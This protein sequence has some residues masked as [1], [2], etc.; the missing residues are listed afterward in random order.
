MS[1]YTASAKGQECTV[2]IPGICNFDRDTVVF[3]HLNGAGIGRKH[4][5]IHGCYACSAC[6]TWLDTGYV[7]DDNYLAHYKRPMKRIIRDFDHLR[8]MVETQQI[9]I[10]NGV[11]KL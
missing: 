11:L 3:A 8:A 1:R 9:M 7:Q 2:R 6:H 5:D 4:I 10:K